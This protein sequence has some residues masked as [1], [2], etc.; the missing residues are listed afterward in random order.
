MREKNASAAILENVN[1]YDLETGKPTTWRP[2][3]ERSM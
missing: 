1:H 3:P 2:V